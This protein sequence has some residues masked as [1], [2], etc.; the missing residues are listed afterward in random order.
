[1]P[2]KTFL[3]LYK[4]PLLNIASRAEGIT[5]NEA[6]KLYNESTTKFN[7]KMYRYMQ[8]LLNKSKG[9][10]NI[11][12]NRNPTINIGSMM[13]LKIGEVKSDINDL[14]LSISNNILSSLNADFDGDVLNIIALFTFKQKQDFANLTPQNLIIS[15]N[16]GKFNRDFT[17]AKDQ[18]LGVYIL[19]N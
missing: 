5:F 8:E 4:F 17:L 9:G 6:N 18:R 14:T 3:E 15:N 12:L 2:Y 16:N 7:P 10:V 11:I 1:M 13:L 19:N